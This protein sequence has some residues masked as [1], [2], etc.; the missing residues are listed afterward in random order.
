MAAITIAFV[1][2][3]QP[4]QHQQDDTRTLRAGGPNKGREDHLSGNCPIRRLM[5]GNT[6]IGT[7]AGPVFVWDY[8]RKAIFVGMNRHLSFRRGVFVFCVIRVLN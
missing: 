6:Y 2:V 7:R 8:H 4:V 5:V 1:V 3:K